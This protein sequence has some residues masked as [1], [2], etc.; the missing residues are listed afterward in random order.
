MICSGL[1]CLSP[2]VHQS[3]KISACAPS[4][5][6]FLSQNLMTVVPHWKLQPRRWMAARQLWRWSTFAALRRKDIIFCDN[7]LRWRRRV[8]ANEPCKQMVP[9]DTAHYYWMR[10][11]LICIEWVRML[12]YG[13]VRGTAPGVCARCALCGV[14]RY[15][16]SE[17]ENQPVSLC[18]LI[19]SSSTKLQRAMPQGI[20][21]NVNAAPA[22][23]ICCCR[24]HIQFTPTSS[25]TTG[26]CT[27]ALFMPGS[28]L[29][30]FCDAGARKVPHF[31]I[32]WCVYPMPV[33]A[34][35]M[36]WQFTGLFYLNFSI[37]I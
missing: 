2:R 19:V 20:I 29:G 21:K 25:L 28:N 15:R 34:L 17:R 27:T 30:K 32:A 3:I 24:C 9:P 12:E 4:P 22:C 7:S 23:V 1:V 33:P 5:P 13:M 26:C 36:I 6:F 11:V 35:T 31:Q 37:L 14:C 10:R 16:A 18:S 8:C